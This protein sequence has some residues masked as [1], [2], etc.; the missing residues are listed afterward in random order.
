MEE[1]ADS[2]TD[3]TWVSV[4]EYAQHQGVSPQAVRKAITEGRIAGAARRDGR[5]WAVDLERA[6]RLWTSRTNAAK[7]HRR[8]SPTPTEKRRASKVEAKARAVLDELDAESDSQAEREELER[9]LLKARGDFNAVRA[10]REEL[11]A[12][13]KAL[14]LSKRSGELID[15]GVAWQRFFARSRRLRDRIL[16]LPERLGPEVAD[17]TDPQACIIKIEAALVTALEEESGGPERG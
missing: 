9:L 14:E 11:E 15:S 16:S 2:L 6:D 10:L 3:R 13:L 5:T 7:A 12:R 17:E 4:S 1:A 8:R